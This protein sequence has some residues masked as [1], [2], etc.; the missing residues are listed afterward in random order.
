MTETAY[1]FWKNLE[2]QSKQSGEL[3]TTQPARLSGNMQVQGETGE[4]V[5]GFFSASSIAEKR[6]LMQP[7]IGF[8]STIVCEP[9]YLEGDTLLYYLSLFHPDYYPLYLYDRDPYGYQGSLYLYNLF[10]KEPLFD[11]AGQDCFDCRFNGGTLK[12]PDYWE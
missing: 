12:R 10:G 9:F 2:D 8:D 6:I 4:T 5:L 1:E 7:N 3:Y 11:Y